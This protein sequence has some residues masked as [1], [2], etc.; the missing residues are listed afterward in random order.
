MGA[1]Q[2]L[3][4]FQRHEMYSKVYELC[5]RI[6]IHSHFVCHIMSRVI[7]VSVSCVLHVL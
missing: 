2:V 1:M 6:I 7:C 4:R 5:S 3:S